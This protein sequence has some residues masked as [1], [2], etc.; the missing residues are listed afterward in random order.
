MTCIVAGFPS[1][2]AAL[3]FEWAWQNSHITRHIAD[4][5]RPVPSSPSKGSPKGKKGRGRAKR[6]SASL[7]Q[8]LSHLHLLLRVPLFCKWPLEVRFFAE[9]VFRT[10]QIWCSRVDSQIPDSIQVKCEASDTV[11][12]ASGLSNEAVVDGVD[13]TYSN[14]IPGLEKS[15]FLMNDDDLECALC[16]GRLGEKTDLIAVCPSTKCQGLFHINCLSGHFLQDDVTSLLPDKGSC[17]SCQKSLKWVDLMKETTL[18]LRDERAV[19]KILKRQK[20]RA[21]GD[22]STSNHRSLGD[23]L[24]FFESGSSDEEQLEAADVVDDD[25]DDTASVTSIGSEASYQAPKTAR[26]RDTAQKSLEPVIEDSE[27]EVI[28]LLSD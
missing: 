21:K 28:D 24:E 8:K 22:P 14:I 12:T 15:D 2:I 20:Q 25:F 26:T 13:V 9:D 5:Q 27:A 4:S 23:E 16:K 17:P 6:P 10:W 11:E 7:T 18:R 3:Q 19:Q 1:N